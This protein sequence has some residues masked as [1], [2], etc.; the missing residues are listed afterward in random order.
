[1]RP[2]TPVPPQTCEQGVT[3]RFVPLSAAA[4]LLPAAEREV[5]EHARVALEDLLRRH[6]AHCPHP[7][8]ALGAPNAPPRPCP[9]RGACCSPPSGGVRR[10]PQTARPETLRLRAR[11]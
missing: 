11:R 6:V 10:A 4:N 7:H 3:T 5:D 1:M 2:P 9:P 8:S